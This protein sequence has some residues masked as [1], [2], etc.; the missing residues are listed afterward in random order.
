MKKQQSSSAA[1]ALV[2]L[3]L[4]GIWSRPNE[5]GRVFIKG[6]DEGEGAV[7]ADYRLSGVLAFQILQKGPVRPPGNSCAGPGCYTVP[8]KPPK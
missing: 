8:P 2:L 4:L 7:R 5:A 1:C 3:L 6:R